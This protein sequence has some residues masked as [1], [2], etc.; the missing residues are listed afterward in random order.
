M[1][2]T[3]RFGIEVEDVTDTKENTK[4]LYSQAHQDLFALGINNYKTNGTY[5]D[6]GC[7]MPRDCNNTFLLEQFGWF[8]LNVDIRAFEKMWEEF[9]VNKFYPCDA[10]KQDYKKL[11]KEYFKD[12]KVIDYLSFDID[13]VSNIVLPMIPFDSYKF[14]CITIEHDLYTGQ[15]EYKK[16]QHE[17]LTQHGYKCLAENV[18]VYEK[19]VRAPFE[20]WWVLPEIYDHFKDVINTENLN[21]DYSDV[22][23]KKLKLKANRNEV[24]VN[25]YDSLNTVIENT[26]SQHFTKIYDTNEWGGSGSGSWVQN[27]QEYKQFL[28]D[29]IKEK[30]IKHVTD[31]GCGDWQ[32][33]ST[34]DWSD[35]DY[36]GVD[37]V[38]SLIDNHTSKYSKDNIKFNF[39]E[40]TEDFYNFKGE[41]LVVKDVLQHWDNQEVVT[42]L[43]SI[44]NN[45]RYILVTNCNAQTYDWDDKPFRRRPLSSKYYPL[46]KYNIESKFQYNNSGGPREISLI[47]SDQEYNIIT[48]NRFKN[49]CDD[50]IDESKPFIS[51]KDKPK[52]IF[53]YTDW[54]KVF[55]QKVLPQIH[56]PF[57]LVTHNSDCPVNN[58][59][60]NILNHHNLIAWYGMNCHIV[61]PKLQ[62]IPIGIANEKWPHGDKKIMLDVINT[63]ISKTDLCY[64]NF[65]LTTNLNKRE[66]IFDIIKTKSFIDIESQKLPFKEYLTKLKKYKYVVSPPGNSIDCHRVWEAIYLGVIPIIEKNTAMEYFNDLPILVVDSFNDLTPELL[67][68]EYS[69]LI[70]KPITK[71][72]FNYYK[73]LICLT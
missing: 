44:K 19:H 8:G 14:K 56:Y 67:E 36:L 43:N 33:S 61:H 50:Y 41:L 62:P 11:F 72:K 30:N 32:F 60:N 45:F 49:I 55:E 38:K 34:I 64:S 5:V 10:T 70:A 40:K 42:F 24:L 4:N 25:R 18:C 31:F 52:I 51:I 29:F 69:K 66:K 48:G 6:I 13:S 20:D 57:K 15:Q 63:D 65:E 1:K 37:C 26:H 3:T 22:I 7:S 68:A 47:E 53:L 46:K 23:L 17:I 39:I 27:T 59:S 28:I 71:A 2:T 9:R 16:L 58:D 12:L 21:N 54:L 35:V 73:N